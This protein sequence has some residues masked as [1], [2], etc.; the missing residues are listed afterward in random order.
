LV[1]WILQGARQDPSSSADPCAS[2]GFRLS[3]IPAH[4]NRIR[5]QARAVLER[6][7]ALLA[8]LEDRADEVLVHAHAP[9]DAVHDDADALL[10][11]ISLIDFQSGIAALA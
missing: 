3:G 6:H 4:E 9:G 11:Y 10:H 8:D 5:H 7:A 2:P 1:F